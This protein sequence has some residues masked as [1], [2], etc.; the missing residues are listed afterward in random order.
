MKNDIDIPTVFNKP[1]FISMLSSPHLQLLRKMFST[2]SN[3]CNSNLSRQVLVILL[4]H[5]DLERKPVLSV[6]IMTLL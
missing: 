3:F 2:N 5:G 4:S 1:T 6:H